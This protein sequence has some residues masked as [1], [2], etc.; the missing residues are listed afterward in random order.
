VINALGAVVVRAAQD[1]P[2]R[3]GGRGGRGGVVTVVEARVSSCVRIA[4]SRTGQVEEASSLY[5]RS[6]E[7]RERLVAVE[8]NNAT[9]QRDLSIA[10]QRMYRMFWSECG[11]GSRRVACLECAESLL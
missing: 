5:R 7:S 2:G 3:V 1:R 8:P 10:Y 9:Y 4:D 6:L 11:P